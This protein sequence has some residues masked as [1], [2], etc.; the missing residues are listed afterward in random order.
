MAR[1][2]ELRLTPRTVTS[3]RRA[4]NEERTALILRDAQ[5]PYARR[6]MALEFDR[7]AFF[8]DAVYAIALT[9]LVVGIAVPTVEDIHS[10][11]EM[12]DVLVDLRAEFVSFFVGFAVIGRYW[13]AHHRFVAVLAAVDTRL[14]AL[15]LVYLAFIAFLPFPTALVGRYEQNAVAFAFFA[16]ILSCVSA[17]ETML[18]VTAERRG[19]LVA[20]VPRDVYRFGVV[21]STLPVVVFV[22]SIPLAAATN[23]TVALLSWVLIWPLEWMLDRLAPERSSPWPRD[24]RT[25][26]T[27]D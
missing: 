10:S 18:F 1:H 13:L 8:S 21:A 14:M 12:W 15:N 4:R 20:T 27:H 9:L 23:S 6:G 19:L 5:G 7:F 17:L 24:T 2:S 16:G 3:D 22:L 11:R 25:S 26:E